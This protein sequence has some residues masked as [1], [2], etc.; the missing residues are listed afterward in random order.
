[1]TQLDSN[2][3]I[4]SSPLSL[5]SKN[6]TF[7]SYSR[8]DKAFVEQLVAKFHQ[9]DREPWVDW[10][11]IYKGEDWWQSIQRGIEE[12]DNFVW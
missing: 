12:S 8:K 1:M 11:D 2:D 9:A 6:D 10:D 5:R 4:T 7:I 3:F